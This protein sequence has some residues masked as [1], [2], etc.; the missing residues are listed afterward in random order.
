MCGKFTEYN[1]TEYKI[2]DKFFK[3]KS[4]LPL[5]EKIVSD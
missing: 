5:H 1:F 2:V 4:R 3:M